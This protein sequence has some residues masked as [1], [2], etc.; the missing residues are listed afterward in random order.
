MAVAVVVA[1]AAA[2]LAVLTVA[3]IALARQAARVASSI[4]RFDREMRPVLEAIESGARR[5]ADRSRAFR[6]RDG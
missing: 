5:A 3:V 4:A 1:L 2:T 6:R